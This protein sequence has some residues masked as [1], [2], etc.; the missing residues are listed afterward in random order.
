MRL[1]ARCGHQQAALP[2][3]MQRTVTPAVVYADKCQAAFSAESSRLL[4][5]RDTADRPARPHSSIQC[6]STPTSHCVARTTET[7]EAPLP[8][9]NK[10][11]GRRARLPGSVRPIPVDLAGT[12]ESAA[13]TPMNLFLSRGPGASRDF[14]SWPD[15]SLSR[16]ATTAPAEPVPTT[17]WSLWSIACPRFGL[18][19]WR[20]DR[21]G[22][23]L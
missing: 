23:L 20:P 1:P 14:P 18:T 9:G 6:E 22:A 16:L 2:G 15:R 11:R 13:G 5:R 3:S 10:F 8:R 19:V 12:A 4:C 21:C 17:T 7:T